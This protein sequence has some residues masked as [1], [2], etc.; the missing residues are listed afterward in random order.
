MQTEFIGIGSINKVKRI[1]QECSAQKILLVTGN[2]SFS[3]CGAES[4]LSNIL[5]EKKVVIFNKFDSNPKIED[6]VSGVDIVKRE[7]PDLIIA[8]GGGSVIDMAKSINIIAA[9]RK[10]KALNIVKDCNLICN[11][12]A[13]LI[14]IPTT[15]GTGSEATH[16][17]VIYVDKKKY[18][19]THKLILP[20]YAIIDFSLTRN[21]PKFIAASCAMDALSQSVESYWSV[22]SNVESKKYAERS[23]RIILQSI[24]DAV[25]NKDIQALNRM[26]LAANL[27]GKAINI[28][29]TTAPHALSYS[30]TALLDISHGHAVAL[31]LGKFFKI[32]FNTNKSKILDQRGNGYLKRT[33]K[34]LFD[35]FGCD[36]ADCCHDKWYDLMDLLGLNSSLELIGKNSNKI[37]SIVDGVNLDRLNNNPVKLSRQEMV[38]L[39]DGG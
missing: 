28:S 39:F 5:K 34:E 17:S 10:Y 27:S 25:L 22:N 16:F 4:A 15:S 36:T 30:I 38:D 37:E 35:M 9:Q 19:L 7:H 23:I 32:N 24:S 33:M 2:K 8:I 26:A 1:V 3:S 21:V 31:T 11:K 13:P 6:V 18:S 29:K 20:D 14:A 12:G